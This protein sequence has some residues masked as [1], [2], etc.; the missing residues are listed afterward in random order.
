MTPSEN[1]INLVKSFEGFRDKAYL[2][3]ANVWTIGYGTTCGVKDGDYLTE[4]QA[5]NLLLIEIINKSKDIDKLV[6][7]NINQ[8]QFDALCSLVYNIGVNA[9]KDS[10]LLKLINNKDTITNILLKTF[11]FLQYYNN[12]YRP[13]YHLENY[14]YNL[15]TIINGYKTCT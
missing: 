2:C 12:N 7:V 5:Q 1:C 9:F 11:I 14:M 8:N 10:T 13:I 4:D 15:I 6:T 3:P